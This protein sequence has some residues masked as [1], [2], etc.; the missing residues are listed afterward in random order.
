MARASLRLIE[1]LRE[2]AARLGHRKTVYRWSQLAHCNCGHL[3]QTITGLS[4]R[5]I[6]EAA[7]RHRGDWAEQARTIA[8]PQRVSEPDYG[9]RPALDEGAWEPEDLGRCPVAELEMTQI[10]AELGAWGLDPSDIGALERLD[11]PDV[12][13]RLRTNTVDFL[14]SDRT[15]VIA[16]LL[17]WADLLEERLAPL[18][19]D[20]RDGAEG[21]AAGE[22]RELGVDDLAIAAE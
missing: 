19:V 14:Q 8:P 2:T 20:A 17:A 10:F 15:N 21:A 6:G 11:D 7:A 16:Y 4:P 9:S 12:R 5:A 3:A 18:T 22:T 13:R 1:A